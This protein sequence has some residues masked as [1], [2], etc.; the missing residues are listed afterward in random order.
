MNIERT[1][2]ADVKFSVSVLLHILERLT[3][4]QK[5]SSA[6]GTD[7]IWQCQSLDEG[8]KGHDKNDIV[9]WLIPNRHQMSVLTARDALNT[10]FHGGCIRVPH[11]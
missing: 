3:R 9:S 6:S 7:R 10:P 5:S 11:P 8:S 2:E 4:K 1:P